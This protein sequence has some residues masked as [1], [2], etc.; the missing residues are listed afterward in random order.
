MGILLFLP[1]R[2]L[3]LGFLGASLGASFA[4]FWCVLEGYRPKRGLYRAW[5]RSVL[6]SIDSFI[7]GLRDS[8][9]GRAAAGIG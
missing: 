4:Y 7:R 1:K 6:R 2:V 3:F 9:D 5:L 8:V